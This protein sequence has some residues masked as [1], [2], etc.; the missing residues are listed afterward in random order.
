MDDIAQDGLGKLA[1]ARRADPGQA[2]LGHMA[3]P[4]QA[5]PGLARP[6]VAWPGWPAVGR[7]GLVSPGKARPGLARPGLA[8]PGHAWPGLD[9]PSVAQ[10]QYIKRFRY[11]AK[12][13]RLDKTF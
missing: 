2:W 1:Q 8:R 10:T 7:L 9:L 12:K 5:R 3:R 11:M 4:G 6:S 13:M